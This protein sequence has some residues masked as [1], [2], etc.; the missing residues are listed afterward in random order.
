[1]SQ[2]K[3]KVAIAD[4]HGLMRQGIASMLEHV[5]DIVVVGIV[6]GGEE[7]V[8]LTHNFQPDVFLMDIM[9]R[10]M[11][12]IEAARWITDINPSIKIILIS[13]EANKEFIS[14]GI[15]AGIA[16]YIL[17]DTDKDGLLKAIHAVMKG[18]RYFSPEVMTIVF[19][20]FYDQEKEERQA[21]D[22]H[23]TDLTRREREV[24]K[25]IA[26]GRSLKEIADQ[27]FISIK[28]VETHKLNM[29]TKLNLTNTAQLVRYAIEKGLV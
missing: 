23:R 10:G 13:S 6:E 3:I 16:G 26:E 12:G 22:D 7:A 8:N 20:D 25:L 18:E 24:I 29:Q 21:A 11:T 19:H 5:P 17:K 2:T 15:K 27:L 14:T 4:D 1:M 28:T 9:M